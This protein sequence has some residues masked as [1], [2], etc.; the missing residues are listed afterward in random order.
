MTGHGINICHKILEMSRKV[1]KNTRMTKYIRCPDHDDR[2]ASAILNPDGWVYCMACGYKG[3]NKDL[4]SEDPVEVDFEQ[5]I[6]N[7]RKLD[8]PREVIEEC[9]QALL[10][11]PDTILRLDSMGIGVEAI[12]AYMVGIWHDRRICIPIIEQSGQIVNIRLY[13]PW[14]E[15]DAPKIQHYRGNL[16]W[17]EKVDQS[18]P[19]GAHCLNEWKEPQIVLCEGESDCLAAYTAGMQAMAFV[20]GAMYVPSHLVCDLK[21]KTVVVAYDNDE[22][23]VRGGNRIMRFLQDNNI[24]T[25]RFLPDGNDLREMLLAERGTNENY[26]GKNGNCRAR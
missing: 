13:N 25:I 15:V 16:K 12:K 23:G 18:T 8:V 2:K 21:N 1:C 10:N 20:G 26:R 24:K 11:S 22:A 14:S 17:E 9:H 19:M 4:L 6:K 5:R 3:Y 7:K